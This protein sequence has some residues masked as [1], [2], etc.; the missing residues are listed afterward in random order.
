VTALNSALLGRNLNRIDYN[1]ALAYV[2]HARGEILHVY[3]I[4]RGEVTVIL[5]ISARAKSRVFYVCN[6]CYDSFEKVI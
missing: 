2:M 6:E 5:P 3:P 4:V 1:E